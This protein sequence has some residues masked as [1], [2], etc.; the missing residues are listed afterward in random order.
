M[1][2]G[3]AQSVYEKN[4]RPLAW[5]KYVGSNRDWK[6]GKQIRVVVAVVWEG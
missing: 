3:F 2:A 1:S 4:E 5:M 6:E